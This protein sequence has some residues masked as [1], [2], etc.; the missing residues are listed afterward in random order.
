MRVPD[1]SS[2]KA[3]QDVAFACCDNIAVHAV[4]VKPT[5]TAITNIVFISMWTPAPYGI[6]VYQSAA[7]AGD[8]PQSHN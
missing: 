3:L 6:Y 1:C 4:A 8:W 2:K 7:P 5:N